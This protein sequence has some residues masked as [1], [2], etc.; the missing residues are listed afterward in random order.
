VTPC[1]LVEDY[2][3]F[4][5][6]PVHFYQA[7]LRHISEDLCIDVLFGDGGIMRN[8]NNNNNNNKGKV[9]LFLCLINLILRQKDVW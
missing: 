7:T 3:Y 2:W 5:E 1:C 6:T 4:R 8:N 9:K